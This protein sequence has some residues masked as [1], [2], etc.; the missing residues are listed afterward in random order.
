MSKTD[1][2]ALVRLSEGLG[3]NAQPVA[4]KELSAALDT[5]GSVVLIDRNGDIVFYVTDGKMQ[6]QRRGRECDACI[7]ENFRLAEAK[8]EASC[9]MGVGCGTRGVCYAEKMGRPEE[10]GGVQPNS[11]DKS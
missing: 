9:N 7:A 4:R 11:T 2:P 3:P 6:V 1:P 8:A 10:C 5:G